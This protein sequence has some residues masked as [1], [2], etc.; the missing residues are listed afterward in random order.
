MTRD[1]TS[2]NIC[3]DFGWRYDKLLVCVCV[4]STC[5]AK[6]VQRCW[7]SNI[8]WLLA[9]FIPLS[10]DSLMHCLID[11]FL[12]SPMSTVIYC[13]SPTCS[14]SALNVCPCKF[15]VVTLLTSVTWPNRNCWN[16]NYFMG[17]TSFTKHFAFIW[18]RSFSWSLHI[19]LLQDFSDA[20]WRKARC[21]SS[22]Q[23]KKLPQIRKT[24]KAN[25]LRFQSQNEKINLNGSWRADCDS[26]FM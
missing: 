26:Y 3:C 7:N 6:T 21:N 15:V 24:R 13:Q 16:L 4:F 5:S 1:L 20:S 11:V 19:F 10:Q 25:P 2:F 12:Q 23:Q 9:L 14:S 18:S 22:L 17:K 8:C